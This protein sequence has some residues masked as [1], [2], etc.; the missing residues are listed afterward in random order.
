ML[1]AKNIGT[2]DDKRGSERGEIALVN[3]PG[4]TIGQATFR[5]GWKWSEDIGPMVGTHSCQVAH[6]GIVLSGRFGVRMDDGQEI[7]LGPGDAHVVAPGHDAWVI[8][9]EEC[10]ILD[11]A[12]T[13]D[14]APG[15]VGRCPCGVEFRVADDG[16]L[17]HLV[18]AI[19]EHA[20]A[21]HQH[22]LTRDQVLADLGAGAGEGTGR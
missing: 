3:L 5:P 10:V 16:Q 18:A 9:D 6:A 15:R 12:A 20:S 21:S 2:P 8:G 13:G 17:D 11:F 22:Q 4:A 1:H 7:E 19:Q 14:V